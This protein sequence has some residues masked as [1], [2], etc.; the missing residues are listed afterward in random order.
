VNINV[1]T[2]VGGYYGGHRLAVSPTIRFRAGDKL[3]GNLAINYNRVSLPQG[4]FEANLFKLRASYSFSPRIFVQSLVQYNQQI[5]FLSGNFRFGW[6]QSANAGFFIVYN[7]GR[8]RDAV[9]DGLRD[10]SSL[11]LVRDRSLVI[12]FSRLIDVFR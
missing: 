10:D 1:M 3:S 6:L 7:E 8:E 12:K 9:I 5:G 2:V 11:G 4:E